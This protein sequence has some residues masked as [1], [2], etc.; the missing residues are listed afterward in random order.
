MQGPSTSLDHSQANDRTPLRMTVS[1][2]GS[3][4]RSAGVPPA[5]RWASRPPFRIALFRIAGLSVLLSHGSRGTHSGAAPRFLAIR[6][7]IS[8]SLPARPHLFLMEFR[9]L[10]RSG[11]KVPVLSFG[12][13]TFGG[14]GEF[15]RA[16]GSSDVAE[17]SRLVSICLEAGVNLFDT[18]DV[19][20]RGLSEEILGKAVEG[21]RHDVLI[22]TKTTFRMGEGPNNSRIFAAS[23]V[24]RLRS[25][26]APPGHRL[27]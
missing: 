11:L 5:V 12:A 24:E 1:C 8:A 3:V 22:S 14:G 16:W 6:S 17:A 23:R 2:Y 25:Q 26:P 9:Q 4:Q 27:H 18:A 19:Y 21:R 15:F 13:A 20:S 7:A 10:G